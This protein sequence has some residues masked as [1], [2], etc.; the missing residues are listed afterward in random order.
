MRACC[1]LRASV[2]VSRFVGLILCHTADWHLGRTLHGASFEKAHRRFLAWLVE[3]IVAR[4]V[5]VLIVAGDVFDRSVPSAAAEALFYGFLG[6]LARAAPGVSVV[7]VAG[8]HDGPAR[9]AAP[10]PLLA[11]LGA[12]A[13][14]P[15]RI[16]G[17][18]PI[19]ADGAIDASAVVVPLHAR[20]GEL[21]GR[22]VAVPF[23]RPS[24]LARAPVANDSGPIERAR[25]IHGELVRAAMEARASEDEVLVA[26]GHGQLRGA[27]VSPESER[28]LLGGVDAALPL[29][30]FPRELDYVALGH[31]HLAQ[32]FED[33]RV[34]YS[35]APLPLAFSE[36]AYPHQVA[37]V[38]LDAAERR[39]VDEVRVPRF[40]EL[41]RVEGEAGAPL[42][43][44]AALDCL[45]ALGGEACEH[46]RWVQVRVRL[47][48]PRAALKRELSEALGGP[49]AAASGDAS[50]RLVSVEVVRDDVDGDR[51]GATSVRDELAPHTVLSRAW[52]SVS[53]EPLP[54]ALSRALDV[55]WDEARAEHDVERAAASELE[56]AS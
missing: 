11:H 24:D 46:E 49:N 22:L 33:G 44:G 20:S 41:S 47:S 7:V 19:T 55:A 21:R 45:R 25:A 56:V 6:E 37:I 10:A 36:R 34:R 15:L 26:T 42:D 18:L 12:A 9:L 52:S 39:V 48:S 35:G 1:Q 51:V 27:R 32:S 31:L 28:P 2:A 16:V 38:E 54:E 43:L 50:T 40:V 29:D 53:R 13:R 5:D 3:L 17:S 4:S 14:M 30:V 8:N 23:L